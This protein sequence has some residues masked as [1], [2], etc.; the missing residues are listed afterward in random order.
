MRCLGRRVGVYMDCTRW[1]GL[2]LDQ[3]GVGEEGSDWFSIDDFADVA[4][5]FEVEDEEGDVAFL[6][7]GQGSHVHDSEAFFECFF[8]GE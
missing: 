4:W 6:A 2:V 8:E 3:L 5:D 1:M 7:H